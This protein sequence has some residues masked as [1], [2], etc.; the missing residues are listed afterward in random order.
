[1]PKKEIYSFKRFIIINKTIFYRYV[2]ER[3]TDLIPEEQKKLEKAIQ[4]KEM[5]LNEQKQ[6]EA[7]LKAVIV[8]IKYLLF[9]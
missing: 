5:V 1:M 4:K 8:N 9:F 7:N 3:E 2:T 6:L